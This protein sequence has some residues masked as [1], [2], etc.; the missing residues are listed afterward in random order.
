MSNHGQHG[1]GGHDMLQTI[2]QLFQD[3]REEVARHEELVNAG[4]LAWLQNEEPGNVVIRDTEISRQIGNRHQ[5]HRDLNFL[6]QSTHPRGRIYVVGCFDIG[7]IDIEVSESLSIYGFV[8]GEQVLTMLIG[9]FRFTGV[10]NVHLQDLM[11]V[12][13]NEAYC[14]EN[15]SSEV[16]MIP[17]NVQLLREN[18]F[19]PILV[20]GR[21]R[22]LFQEKIIPPG[23]VQQIVKLFVVGGAVSAGIYWIWLFY[24]L[25]MAGGP[26][27]YGP[28]AVIF[29]A[30]ALGWNATFSCTVFSVVGAGITNASYYAY[31][32]LTE[33]RRA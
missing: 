29:G 28:A 15:T 1:T 24:F 26:V 19:N 27:T 3:R 12:S 4:V 22:G 16:E 17:S 11:I 6:S 5:I 20:R 13:K 21:T 8:D 18:S 30:M 7:C 9:G 10:G 31:K 2:M 33:Y 25:A 14:V 23:S 32:F